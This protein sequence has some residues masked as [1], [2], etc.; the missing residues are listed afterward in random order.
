MKKIVLLLCLTLTMSFLYTSTFAE[1]NALE[2]KS[3]IAL[4]ESQEKVTENTL[5]SENT[6]EQ[7]IET[8]TDL[9]EKWIENKNDARDVINSLSLGIDY[10][11]FLKQI[12]DSNANKYF[13]FTQGED[14]I[15]KVI[16]DDKSYLRG[17]VYHISPEYKEYSDYIRATQAE[18]I[19]QMETG[20]EP[21][22]DWTIMTR[23]STLNENDEIESQDVWVV[24]TDDN[25]VHYVSMDGTYLYSI[26]V[27][28]QGDAVSLCGNDSLY[29]FDELTGSANTKVSDAGVE[30]MKGKDNSLYLGN[31]KR[32]ILLADYRDY[33][34]N[35]TLSSITNAENWDESVHLVEAYIQAFDYFD[36]LD[37][38]PLLILKDPCDQNG[39]PIEPGYIGYANGWHLFALN[40][41]WDSIPYDVACCVN[42]ELTDRHELNNEEK[43]IC[44]IESEICRCMQ[45]NEIIESNPTL[46]RPY[47]QTVIKDENTL[48]KVANELYVSDMSLKEARDFWCAVHASYVPENDLN[49]LLPWVLE[50]MG[51]K[52][53]E[54]AVK[55][56]LRN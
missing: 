12:V 29:V 46:R 25:T 28:T 52:R 40:D 34:D 47:Y 38:S 23:L 6:E 39:N 5:K 2:T 35:G 33:F 51:M 48:K 11:S 45:K 10:Y 8:K 15:I 22:F 36:F 54:K 19:V 32:K 1:E 7:E 41:D 4:D 26:P 9:K 20:E 44:E 43:T 50:N 21:I 13:I 53:Y 17:I 3:E 37:L 31:A 24:Y 55:K 49:T 30:L 42:E 16:T 56:A 18:Q 14:G 27:K